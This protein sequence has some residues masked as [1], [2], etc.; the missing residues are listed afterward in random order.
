MEIQE[1]L[2]KGCWYIDRIGGNTTYFRYIL[3]MFCGL[4]V[5]IQVKFVGS[6]R[7]DPGIIGLDSHG[8]ITYNI[9]W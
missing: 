8:I 4:G 5:S 2:G 9:R 3:H 6:D 7:D 1:E